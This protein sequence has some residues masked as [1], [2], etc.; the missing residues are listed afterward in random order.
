MMQVVRLSPSILGALLGT[1]VGLVIL[2]PQLLIVLILTVAGYLIGRIW[3][4][5]ELRAKIRELFAMLF[6]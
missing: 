4:S 1:L 5:E 3:E 6:R 2:Y